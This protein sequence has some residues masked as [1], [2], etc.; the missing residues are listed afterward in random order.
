MK[1]TLLRVLVPALLL[2][3]ATL[4]IQAVPAGSETAAS[5]ERLVVPLSKPGQPASFEV[6]VMFGSVKI[7]GLLVEQRTEQ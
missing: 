2:A 3:A 6:D 4:T 5:P 1:K 7:S